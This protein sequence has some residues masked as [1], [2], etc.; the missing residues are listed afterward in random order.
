MK[1]N[2]SCQWINSRTLCNL[3]VNKHKQNIITLLRYCQN[4]NTSR[5]TKL[6]QCSAHTVDSYS[7]KVS[8][9]RSNKLIL[10]DFTTIPFL[11]KNRNSLSIYLQ[12]CPC[13]EVQQQLVPQNYYMIKEILEDSSTNFITVHSCFR[14]TQVFSVSPS[15]PTV[16]YLF[17]PMKSSRCTVARDHLR[18]HLTYSR[19][20]IP[21]TK[22][23]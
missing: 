12:L 3:Y 10:R 23:C 4:L 15:T 14:L 6:K 22:T 11:L 19:S 20:S 18:C 21:L 17:T 13:L 2:F 9:F 5:C 8:Y 1:T 16:V 7:T